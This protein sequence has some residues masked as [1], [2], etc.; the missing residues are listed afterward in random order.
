MILLSWRQGLSCT[1]RE[2][3]SK[4]NEESASEAQGLE[5]S[6]RPGPHRVRSDGWFCGRCSWCDY[7]WR[8]DQ[9]QPDLFEGFFRS[10]Q[11]ERQLVLNA[12]LPCGERAG[13]SRSLPAGFSAQVC[14]TPS[15][16]LHFRSRLSSRYLGNTNDCSRGSFSNPGRG[17]SAI[18][19]LASS[20][21]PAS[22]KAAA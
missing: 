17:Q 12:F 8:G 20:F 2:R 18:S 19:F 13:L 7:A 4:R 11:R 6:A 22:A 16:S 14:S 15:A 1:N 9:H 5:R 21:C 3:R 10:Q